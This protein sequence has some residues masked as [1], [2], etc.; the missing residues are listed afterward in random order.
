MQ[1]SAFQSLTVKQSTQS[2]VRLRRVSGAHISKNKQCSTSSH[3][4]TLHAQA[5]TINS[6]PLDPAVSA[7]WCDAFSWW[8]SS[9][10]ITTCVVGGS[11]RRT[12]FGIAQSTSNGPVTGRVIT[13][14]VTDTL[15]YSV[16]NTGSLLRLISLT[17]DGVCWQLSST[18]DS[19][20]GQWRQQSQQRSQPQGTLCTSLSVV[21]VFC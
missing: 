14:P 9:R 15:C 16:T 1:S 5:N 10:H 18:S 20:A 12:L 2:A 8:I 17:H 11:P 13:G 4:N 21:C 3:N 7:S 6:V 19:I